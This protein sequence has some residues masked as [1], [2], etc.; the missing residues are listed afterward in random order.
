MFLNIFHKFCEREETHGSLKKFNL[1]V[2]FLV[3]YFLISYLKA[4]WTHLS[5]NEELFPT[6][7]WEIIPYL[8]LW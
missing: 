1:V 3:F 4:P 7:Q 5:R 2:L 6:K 8:H